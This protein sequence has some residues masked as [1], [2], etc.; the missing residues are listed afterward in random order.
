[1][2]FFSFG[3][4]EINPLIAGLVSSNLPVFVAIKLAVT[5]YAAAVFVLAEKPFWAGG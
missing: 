5:A 1:L 3:A 2:K 4:R